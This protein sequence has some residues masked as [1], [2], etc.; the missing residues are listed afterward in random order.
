MWALIKKDSR[1]FGF[2]IGLIAPLML[3]YL[4]LK[5]DTVD[6][7]FILLQSQ[8]IV[9]LILGAAVTTEQREGKTRGYAFLKTLPLTLRTLVTAKF[10]LVLGGAFL[11]TAANWALLSC[12]PAAQPFRSLG[13]TFLIL[14]MNLALLLTGVMYC[15][16]FRLGHMRAAWI[17]WM[18]YFLLFIS[19]IVLLELSAA[20]RLDLSEIIR[21]LQESAVP[22]RFLFTLAG[23]T[24]FTGLWYSA[25]RAKIIRTI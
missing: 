8:W 17:A 18:G 3:T 20:G 16:R 15:L 23:L 19:P 25:L 5:K 13:G 10:T 22:I 7:G 12:I 14:G 6:D 1:P 9:L 2:Y 24:G 4:I 11:L 21:Y